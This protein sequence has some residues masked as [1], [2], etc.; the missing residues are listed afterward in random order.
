MALERL[1]ASSTLDNAARDWPNAEVDTDNSLRQ[2][3]MKKTYFRY[4]QK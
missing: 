3:V 1:C 4:S 2:T